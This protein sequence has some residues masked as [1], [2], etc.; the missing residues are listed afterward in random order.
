MC[1]VCLPTDFNYSPRNSE[2]YAISLSKKL[3]PEFCHNFSLLFS[4][5]FTAQLKI[6]IFF[7]CLHWRLF[8]SSALHRCLGF[9]PSTGLTHFMVNS[10]LG[11]SG[12]QGEKK[13]SFCGMKG[14]CWQLLRSVRARTRFCKPVSQSPQC[15]CV[16][17]HMCPCTHS[18]RRMYRLRITS[19]FWCHPSSSHRSCLSSLPQMFTQ[20]RHK[21][22]LSKD[23]KREVGELKTPPSLQV[24][25]WAW[26]RSQQPHA[27]WHE[28]HYTGVT[29]S[30]EVLVNPAIIPVF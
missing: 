24:R 11:C 17:P 23:S 5:F 7:Q 25:S 16:S 21:C 15:E 6:Q 8:C 22:F 28:W 13:C 14:R 10:L 2:K 26:C 20:D 29:A 3:R 9:V 18:R 4:S 30:Q 12:R 19:Y 1:K 27:C